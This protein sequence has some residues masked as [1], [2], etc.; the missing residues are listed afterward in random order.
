M[1]RMLTIVAALMFAAPAHAAVQTVSDGGFVVQTVV[2]TKADPAR[3]WK[4]FLKVQDWWAGSHTYSGDARNLKLD[5]RAGGCWCEKLPRGGVVKHMEVALL[6]P[7]RTVRLLG[8]L[9]PLQE[10]AATGALTA[11]FAGAA[12]GGSTITV[13]YVVNGAS[14]GGWAPL[15]KAVDGVITEQVQRYA[16]VADQ[17]AGP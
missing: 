1:I 17:S 7:D 9:G 3:A 11:Q 4:T 10:M 13:T 15:A 2:T 5:A 16:G 8:A 12:D 14:P 6:I